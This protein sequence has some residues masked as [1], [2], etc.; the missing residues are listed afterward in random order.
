MYHSLN[1]GDSD[2]RKMTTQCMEADQPSLFKTVREA[3]NNQDTIADST[4]CERDW[5][6]EIKERS[7]TYQGPW[8]TRQGRPHL[9]NQKGY[10]E[11][12]QRVHDAELHGHLFPRRGGCGGNAQPDR[13]DVESLSSTL[14]VVRSSSQLDHSQMAN[15]EEPSE[16]LKYQTWVLKVPIHCKGCKRKVKKV[17][18]SID[19]SEGDSDG[20]QQQKPKEAEAEGKSSDAAAEETFGGGKGQLDHIQR[21]S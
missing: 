16:P 14:V 1:Y 9:M 6:M 3:P 7:S 2:S 12:E 8:T 20:Q 5:T 13:A 17:L 15:K 10:G 19:A 4:E 11:D 18:H 21:T